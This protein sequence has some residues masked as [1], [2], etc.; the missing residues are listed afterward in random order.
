[1][2]ETQ[3]SSMG[4]SNSNSCQD[5]PQEECDAVLGQNVSVKGIVEYI[6][7]SRAKN[8]IVMVGAGMSCSA[9]IPDFRSPGTGLYDNLQKYDLP[10]PQAIFSIDYFRNRPSA[11]YTLAKEMWPGQYSPTPAHLFVR[12]L[13]QK[14][15]LLRCFSQNIDS[16]EREAGISGDKIVAAHGNFDSATCISNN[17]KVPIE[18]VKAAVNGGPAACEALRAKWGGLVK[19][20]IVFFGENLPDRFHEL[21]EADFEKADMLIVIGTSLQVMPFAGLINNVKETVPRLLINLE[22]V[23]TAEQG[24]KG[25]KGFRFDQAHNYRDVMLQAKCDAGVWLLAN[26]LGWEHDLKLL[27]EKH[28]VT[29]GAESLE[30]AL[31]RNW[32][33]EIPVLPECVGITAEWQQ[34]CEGCEIRQPAEFEVEVRCYDEM[35]YTTCKAGTDCFERC[36]DQLQLVGSEPIQMDK[37]NNEHEMHELWLVSENKFVARV[38]PLV[39]TISEGT[40][41][42]VMENVLDQLKNMGIDPDALNPAQRAAIAAKYASFGDDFN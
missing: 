41:S 36:H 28:G 13:E 22:V 15:L 2:G 26:E 30:G 25:S 20:D 18:E 39:A 7:S 3:A 14:G 33:G 4:G 10:D 29:P 31:D 32:R 38:G 17:K 5:P 37:A 1:M 40:S 8:I 23:G 12:L 27:V 42:E 6:Q 34:V 11:F 9:G 16:L 21:A 24:S 19:P 35:N